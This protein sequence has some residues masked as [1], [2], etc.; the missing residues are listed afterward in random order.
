MLV[1]HTD[2]PSLVCSCVTCIYSEKNEERVSGE[3]KKLEERRRRERKIDD[4][5]IVLLVLMMRER[6]HNQLK[7]LQ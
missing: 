1:S 5:M 3:G 7:E 4:F 6:T 2:I